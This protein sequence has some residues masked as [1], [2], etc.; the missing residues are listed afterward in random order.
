M[1][2]KL[3][4]NARRLG[5][6]SLRSRDPRR[7]TFLV[8][9]VKPDLAALSCALLNLFDN[10]TGGSPWLY[11]GDRQRPPPRTLLAP[12]A[13]PSATG[14]G[15]RPTAHPDVTWAM[16]NARRLGPCSLRSQGPRRRTLHIAQVTS[17]LAALGSAL[18]PHHSA[19]P[20][21]Q[22]CGGSGDS[23]TR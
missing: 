16:C 12:L 17:D 9:Q 18:P 21:A 6:R 19:P 3:K 20:A 14:V 13:R 8:S 1:L 10:L 23:D 22:G 4:L 11:L 2:L 15:S 5:P 7:R